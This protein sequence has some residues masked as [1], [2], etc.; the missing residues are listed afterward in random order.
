MEMTGKAK[1]KKCHK[2]LDLQHFSTKFGI[3]Q[4]YAV[5]PSLPKRGHA[6]TLKNKAYSRFFQFSPRYFPLPVYRFLSRCT[7]KYFR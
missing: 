3:L 7:T 2:P 1:K 5:P 6:L 4:V